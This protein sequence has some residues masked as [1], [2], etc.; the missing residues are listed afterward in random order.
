ME[1]KFNQYKKIALV[2]VASVLVGRYVLQPKA[3]IKTKE[4]VK[5]VEVYKEK[6]E[7]KKKVKT[8]I[9]ERINV[10]GSK[11]ITTVITDDSTTTEQ[12]NRDSILDSSK[13]SVIKKGS[14]LTLGM[15][16]IADT[17]RISSELE[18]GIT[19]TLPVF[20][21]LKAQALVTTDK[22]I[23]LGFAMDF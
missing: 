10:D 4:V 23:G 8:T 21:N 17:G 13:K 3:E 20:G 15:L 9:K 5:Y 11:E 2:A 19:A 22:K 12:T 16:A 7:E 1:K 18:Y 14:S 6:K